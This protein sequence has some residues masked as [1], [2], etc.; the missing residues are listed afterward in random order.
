LG[1]QE[2]GEV[3]KRSNGE[4]DAD[5]KALAEVLVRTLI[6]VVRWLVRRYGLENLVKEN[7]WPR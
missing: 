7:S 3:V 5:A 2:C 6:Y 1:V 4:I